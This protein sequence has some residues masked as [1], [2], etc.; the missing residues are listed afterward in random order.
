MSGQPSEAPLQRAAEVVVVGGTYRET[1]LEPT[2]DSLRGSGLRAAAVLASLGST[3]SFITCID[4]ASAGEAAA[5]SH[6]LGIVTR[7]VTRAAPVTF[8]YETP[9]STAQWHYGG[10]LA[11]LDVTGSAVVAFGMVD[12]DWKVTADRLVIDPQHGDLSEML[13]ATSVAEAVAV[14][15]N[16]HEATRLTG[17]PPDEAGSY[18]LRSGAAV[19]VIKQ[20]ALGGMVFHGSV[21]EVYGP[22]PT[23]VTRTLG[24]GDAFTAGFAHAW[25]E[26]PG[27]PLAAAQF[28]ARTAAAHS[29]TDVP[30]VPQDLLD[31]L[32]APL[33]YPLGA[34]PRIYLAAPFF[35]TA[36]RLL[37]ETVRTALFDA[38]LNVF[39]PLHD[40]GAG[41]DE[42]AP[43]DLEGLGSCDAV[44]ALL[45]GA[46][47]GTVFE[48]GWATHADIPVV[49]FTA[50][51]D[52]H[53]LTMLR[54]TGA[55]LS[56]DL[57]SAVHLAAW[58]AIRR[59]SSRTGRS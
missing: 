25:F 52:V 1:C 49:G 42:V 48:A 43:Q 28:G 18:L 21:V 45:D 34:T 35:T 26:D 7:S 41:S 38:G 36:E 57:T 13:N 58:A 15:L 56:S 44:L 47:P 39:S 29:L 53:D 6:D 8:C 46:D 50:Q 54:G 22:I 24:S 23:K 9:V 20:G 11:T 16:G 59:A 12:A 3:C 33:D 10:D 17:L 27:N 30:Q 2:I 19:V 37:L 31:S 32:P 4:D 55:E 40:V 14:V 51:P 5:M